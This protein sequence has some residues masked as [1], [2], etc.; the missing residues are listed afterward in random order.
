M[1]CAPGSDGLATQKWPCE[2]KSRATG[3]LS[4]EATVCL[5]SASAD[6]ISDGPWFPT[7][8]NNAGKPVPNAQYLYVTKY[9][10][11]STC[12]VPITAGSL[13][14][15]GYVADGKCYATERDTFFKATCGGTSATVFSCK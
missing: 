6:Q 3:I 8:T 2:A 15:D 7:E 9:T 13:D 14:Q 1:A 4:S 11:V 12:S 10:G 5:N